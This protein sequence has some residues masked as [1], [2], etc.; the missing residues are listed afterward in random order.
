MNADPFHGEPEDPLGYP[1]DDEHLT[2]VN[3]ANI[4]AGHYYFVSNA[5]SWNLVKVTAVDAEE[6][7]DVR[8]QHIYQ[9][10]DNGVWNMPYGEMPQ[11]LSKASINNG[12][13]KFYKKTEVG[14]RRRS[15]K[16]RRGRRMTRRRAATR[17]HRK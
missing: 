12:N 3:L 7:G 2:R 13:Y 6:D 1:L 8:I 4:D 5:G 11:K 16:T 9:E 10:V 15:R 14:G 17:R